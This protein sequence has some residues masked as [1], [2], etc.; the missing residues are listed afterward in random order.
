MRLRLV[1]TGLGALLLFL[2]T[3]AHAALPVSYLSTARLGAF[4]SKSANTNAA[5]N[6]WLRDNPNMAGA[7]FYEDSSYKGTWTTWPLAVKA[8]FVQYF[9]LIVSWY[10]AGMPPA[11]YPQ[12]FL[13]QI[14]ELGPADPMYGFWMSEALGTQVYLS[15]V[16]NSLAAELTAAFSWS[17]TSYTPSELSLLLSMNDTMNY[18]STVANPGY[19]FQDSGTG[20]SPADPGFT[21]TFFKKSGLIGSDAADTVARLFAWERKLEHFSV[22]SG[23]P[24]Q[25]IYPYFWGPNTPPVPDSE[26]INGTVY[27]GPIDLGFANYTAGCSGTM[28]FMKSVLRSV[29]IP[30]QLQWV[31]CGHA[32]PIFPTIGLAMTHGDDPYDRLG[33]V[34][35]FPGFST[36]PPSEYFITISQYNQ[37]F[38]PGQSLDA[39][40]SAVGSQVANIAIEYGSD[41]LMNLFCEDLASGADEASGQV[42]AYM[43]NY[44]PLQT[45]QNMGLWTTLDAKVTALNYCAQFLL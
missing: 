16:A 31:F 41:F 21:V 4:C 9:N 23:D 13:V 27:T 30:V 1:Q 5:L 8:Q 11:T 7:M 38:P 39:C 2:P 19:Y 29:N 42:Y 40:D 44:Y 35:P 28:Y 34:S 45:L 18:V 10:D 22:V 17:I 43:Q 25:N 24:T 12:L 20:A 36:P 37:V 33:F 14:P 26:V 15:Q 6:C 32:T 3:F